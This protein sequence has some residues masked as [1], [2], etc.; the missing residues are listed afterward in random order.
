MNKKLVAFLLSTGILVSTCGTA[1]ANEVTLN[2]PVETVNTPAPPINT[3]EAPPVNIEEP[4]KEVVEEEKPEEKQEVKDNW[5]EQMVQLVK[6]VDNSIA[7]LQKI[8]K[9]LQE[10]NGM[11]INNLKDYTNATIKFTDLNMAGHKEAF[12]LQELLKKANKLNAGYAIDIKPKIKKLTDEFLIAHSETN[13]YIIDNMPNLADEIMQ[14]IPT[15]PLDKEETQVGTQEPSDFI[16]NNQVNTGNDVGENTVGENTKPIP[17]EPKAETPKADEKFDEMVEQLPEEAPEEEKEKD[18]ELPPFPVSGDMQKEI[19][20]LLKDYR[21]EYEKLLSNVSTVKN[22][23]TSR[24]SG[25]LIDKYNEQVIDIHEKYYNIY[26]KNSDKLGELYLKC[27]L[28][29]ENYKAEMDK[30]DKYLREIDNIEEEALDDLDRI[31]E[32]YSDKIDKAYEALDKKT[33]NTTSTVSETGS[34]IGSSRIGSSSIDSSDFDSI[35]SST[36]ISRLGTS[37]P[38][39]GDYTTLGAS[40]ATMIAGIAGIFVSRKR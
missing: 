36:S 16:N 11:K 1:F 24:Q 30:Y 6:D 20:Q 9:D 28:K 39:T 35:P 15:N 17:E 14:D 29:Y 10:M 13:S 33:T 2:Q 27:D 25:R 7:T 4:T 18:V 19:D 31:D 37:S 8:T 12:N 5:A 23:E 32:E 40:I 26:D 22:T 21:A 34:R 38:K 3:T